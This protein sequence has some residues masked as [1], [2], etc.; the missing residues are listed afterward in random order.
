M[1]SISPLK[2]AASADAPILLVH[3]EDHWL[4]CAA[5]RQAMLNA[6]VGFVQKHNPAN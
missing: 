4:S 6:V 3:G 5:T 1:D 2:A